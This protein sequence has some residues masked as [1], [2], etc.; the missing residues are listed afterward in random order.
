MKA[1]LT[2]TDSFQPFEVTLRFESLPEVAA[3]WLRS[4][5][6]MSGV[7]K[8]NLNSNDDEII[9]KVA[10]LANQAGK[11]CPD[12]VDC[13]FFDILDDILSPYVE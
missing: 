8:A 1:E 4:N 5:L 2:K 9:Q 12:R 11:G 10:D 3:M 6:A 13:D 7:V